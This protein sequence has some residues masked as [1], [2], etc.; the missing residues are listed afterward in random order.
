MLGRDVEIGGAFLG[1]IAV[2]AAAR[3]EVTVALAG[4]VEELLAGHPMIVVATLRRAFAPFWP[5]KVPLVGCG[6]EQIAAARA[7]NSDAGPPGKVMVRLD[8]GMSGKSPNVA[9]NVVTPVVGSLFRLIVPAR[10]TAIGADRRISGVGNAPGWLISTSLPL[11]GVDRSGV[12]AVAVPIDGQSLIVV[13]VQS[14]AISPGDS[15]PARTVSV[16]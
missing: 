15:A 5:M 14:S 13:S 6:P 3:A 2:A 12:V 9:V 1:V 10:S 7:M 11:T 4:A 8:S 16:A